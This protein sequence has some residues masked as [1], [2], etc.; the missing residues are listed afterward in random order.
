M[1]AFVL[2]GPLNHLGFIFVT[3]N[4]NVLSIKWYTK[5]YVNSNA[6]ENSN[7][8]FV[9]I[10]QIVCGLKKFIFCRKIT[11]N[12]SIWLFLQMTVRKFYITN[13]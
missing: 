7:Y 1:L 12:R 5:V 3:H 10:S 9:F 6:L 11:F 4:E 13:V 2:T 8:P